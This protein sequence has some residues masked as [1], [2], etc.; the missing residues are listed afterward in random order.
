MNLRP[1]HLL[2]TQSYRGKGYSMEFIENMN[3]ITNILRSDK[4]TN[5]N[6]VFSTDDICTKCPLKISDGVCKDDY[7]VQVIDKKVIEY[8]E[9]EEKIYDYKS[10]IN[11]INE[12]ITEDIFNDICSTCNWC[13][14]STCREDICQY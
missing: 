7:K 5:I 9:L 6:L 8:F 13:D 11:K 10:I 1:H 12:K 3:Y 14:T 2:C 4:P